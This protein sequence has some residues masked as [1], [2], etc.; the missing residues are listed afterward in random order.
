MRTTPSPT[1]ASY[2]FDPDAARPRFLPITEYGV[3]GN[4]ETVALVSPF[5]TVDWLCLPHFSSS[6][7]LAR[8]LDP[9]KGGTLEVMPQ[10][11]GRVSIEY[12][13]GTNVLRTQ[14]Q[15]S[16]RRVL[17]IV[18]FMPV[19]IDRPSSPPMLIRVVTARGGPIRVRTLLD[20]R[21]VYGREP[22][23]WQLTTCGAVTQADS[24]RWTYVHPPPVADSARG[25]VGE[26]TVRP[27]EP[28]EIEVIRGNRPTGLA[29]PRAL[30]EQTVRYW[31][32]W[33]RRGAAP[34]ARLPRP[35]RRWVLRSELTLKLLSQRRSGAFVAAATTSIP[36]WPTGGRN[37]DYRYA[38]F[39]DAAFSAQALLLLGHVEEA[40]GFLRW[41]VGRIGDDRGPGGEL[42]VLYDAHGEPIVP[43]HSLPGWSGFLDA[44]P[45]RIGNGAETQFQLDI[46]GELL[47]AAFLLAHLHEEHVGSYWPLLR[48]LAEDVERR[49]TQPDQGIWEARGPPRHYVHS[50]VMA[51]VALDRASE[52]AR[53][54]EGRSVAERFARTANEVRDAIER[55]GWDDRRRSFVQAFDSPEPD[56][57]NLR[58]PL[59]RF[60]GFDD[61]RMDGTV[62]YIDRTLT[63]G[64]FV[65]RFRTDGD[66]M[67]PE[68]AFLACSFWRIEC[69]ARMGR[70]DA[71]LSDWNE[72]LAAAGPLRLFSEEYDP[73]RRRP[74]G[75]YP[76]ALT[77]IG[78]LRS[79]FALASHTDAHA[80]HLTVPHLL[81]YVAHPPPSRPGVTAGPR[82]SAFEDNRRARL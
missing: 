15:L 47:A 48:R 25:I 5:G 80:M 20:A 82:A 72:L 81:E 69:L 4:L 58:L 46:Y 64:P 28:W 3:V 21:P 35:W 67:G 74:L 50:K 42:R 32:S 56:A 77:H 19:T 53:R 36:E 57:A 78:L 26:G 6:S 68:G 55:R 62:R 70:P 17:S 37:W 18:D 49:W 12:I 73:E 27:G 16:A 14:F 29:S 39:R 8:L 34:L 23:R 63:Q 71:A 41:V 65:R 40:E 51:W 33:V 1:P 24:E 66:P 44:R 31:Q 59:V 11:P 38:W 54:F 61:P 76:Q 43:E 9:V 13:T 7:L 10:R 52:L 2:A 22:P 75:N 79:A 60:L 45:V 30:L